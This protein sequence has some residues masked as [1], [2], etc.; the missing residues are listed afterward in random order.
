[1]K[2][3]F[4]AIKFICVLLYSD[5]LKK[6]KESLYEQFWP[7]PT[8]LK[9]RD[10][11]YVYN[12]LQR[13][14]RRIGKILSFRSFLKNSIVAWNRLK[15]SQFI[16]LKSTW[17]PL[18]NQEIRFHQKQSKKRWCYSHGFIG[19]IVKYFCSH[20]FSC[21][22]SIVATSIHKHIDRT[23]ENDRERREQSFIY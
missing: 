2:K 1:M 7:S 9:C 14:M 5:R 21:T 12:M 19:F 4:L 3:R 23:T 16:R 8:D 6:V 17:K 11:T 18:E 15:K 10:S 22:C 20:S 13:T